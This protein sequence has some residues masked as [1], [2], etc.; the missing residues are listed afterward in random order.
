MSTSTYY[1]LATQSCK[2][3][4]AFRVGFGPGS[5]LTFT[6]TLGLFWAQYNAC[7]ETFKTQNYSVTLYLLY[8]DKLSVAQL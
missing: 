1:W 2:S 3:G 6:K 5:G 8:V 4:Q 7:K